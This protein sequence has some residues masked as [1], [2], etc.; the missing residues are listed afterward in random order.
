[1]LIIDYNRLEIESVVERRRR[2]QTGRF[3]WMKKS[4]A[5]IIGKKKEEIMKG[6]EEQRADK[7]ENWKQ[8]HKSMFEKG[9]KINNIGK[10]KH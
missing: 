5:G 10:R 7:T 1:M 2:R 3:V 8:R 4:Q 6:K 9:C